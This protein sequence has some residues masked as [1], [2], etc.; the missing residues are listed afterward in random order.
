MSVTRPNLYR[1]RA[2]V[3]QRFHHWFPELSEN[4]TIRLRHARDSVYTRNRRI[5]PRTFCWELFKL[6]ILFER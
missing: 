5:S 1:C 4:V 2:R 3:R 6:V